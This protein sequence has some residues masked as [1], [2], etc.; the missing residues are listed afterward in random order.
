VWQWVRHGATLEDGRPVTPALVTE[1]MDRRVEKL[2]G[3]L[4]HQLP[5]AANLY[6]EMIFGAQFPEFLTLRAYDYLD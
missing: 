5:V 3:S 2:N 4:G 6:K 1:M